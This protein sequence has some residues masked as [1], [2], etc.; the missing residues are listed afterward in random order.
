MSRNSEGHP[1]S[2]LRDLV[3]P[4]LAATVARRVGAAAAQILER[5]AQPPQVNEADRPPIDL[6]ADAAI[7]EHF[8]RCLA[9][10]P[11][12]MPAEQAVSSRTSAFDW[13]EH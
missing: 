3:H 11:R 4:D 2:L 8:Q 12:S 1:S 10:T 13:L 6:A 7:Q 5:F 9:A